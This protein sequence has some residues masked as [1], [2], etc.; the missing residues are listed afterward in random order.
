MKRFLFFL[1]L[2][3][4]LP[5]SFRAQTYN[6]DSMLLVLPKQAEDTNKVTTLTEIS[7]SY[8]AVGEMEESLDY[9]KQGIALAEKLNYKIGMANLYS[10][11]GALYH[12]LSR[13]AKALSMYERSLQV[14]ESCGSKAGMARVYN[15]I[16]FT[17]FAQSDYPKALEYYFKALALKEKLKDNA[18]IPSTLVNIGNVYYTED[19]PKKALEYYSRAYQMLKKMND[20]QALAVVTS[21]MGLIHND[22]GDTAKAR[23]EYEMALAIHRSMQD[24]NG[25]AITINNIA[26][27]YFDLATEIKEENPAKA[28]QLFEQ[29]NGFYQQSLEIYRKINDKEGECLILTNLARLYSQLKHYSK[30][31]EVCELSLK[32]ARGANLL[33]NAKESEQ[34]LS[35]IFEATG[36]HEKALVHYKAF[37][38][39]KDTIFNEENTRKNVSA[40]MRFEFDK[41]E[42]QAQLEQEKKEAV[43][44]AESKKQRVIIWSICGVLLLVGVFAVFA[45]RSFLQKRKANSAITRQKEIIEEKQKE[46]LD[47]IYYASRIQRSLL[48]GENYISKHLAV[49]SKKRKS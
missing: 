18:S 24:R 49:L 47:S 17:Y 35:E 15:N 28:I 11:T 40:E 45:Y 37:I 14:Y 5:A 12:S 30:A 39:L 31:I 6:T 20:M 22:Q 4:A 26:V 38:L 21:N 2:V 34:V 1:T 41:K 27:M 29:A 10:N 16:G 48:P 36:D 19:D 46:I 8:R 9:A 33:D 23:A 13:Y 25:E 3:Y 7:W 32:I 42:A 44:A 43:S